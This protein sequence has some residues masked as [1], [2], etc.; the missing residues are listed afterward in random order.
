MRA[1]AVAVLKV[2][3]RSKLIVTI[4]HRRHSSGI[5]GHDHNVISAVAGGVT[6]NL[7][8]SHSATVT[9]QLASPNPDT[10]DAAAGSATTQLI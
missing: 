6:V 9:A 3:D 10:G 5:C 2:Q 1:A 7:T 4:E 8:D